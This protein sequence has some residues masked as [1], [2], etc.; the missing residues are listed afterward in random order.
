MDKV[1]E[2]GLELL[3]MSLVVAV[4]ACFLAAWSVRLY[5]R[6]PGWVDTFHDRLFHKIVGLVLA[7]LLA[8]LAVDVVRTYYPPIFDAKERGIYVSRFDLDDKNLVQA[9]VFEAVTFMLNQDPAFS[10][11]VVRR[12]DRKIESASEAASLCESTHAVLCIWG[13]YIPPKPVYVKLSKAGSQGMAE[14]LFADYLDLN[15]LGS[16][17]LKTISTEP[18]PARRAATLEARISGLEIAHR[19]LEAQVAD[20]RVSQAYQGGPSDDVEI[21]RFERARRRIAL[22]VGVSDYQNG[23]PRLA[24]GANDAQAVGATV[25]KLWGESADL[26]VLVDKSATR[27]SIL[28]KLD[29]IVKSAGPNDQ[30]LVYLSGHAVETESEGAVFL[31]Y[32]AEAARIASTGIRLHSLFETLDKSKSGQVILLVDT[33]YSAFFTSYAR[34]IAPQKLSA[35][36]LSNAK[37]RVILAAT[38]ANE[39]AFDSQKAGHGIF[40]NS[41]LDGFS[42]KADQNNDGFITAQELGQYSL[43]KVAEDARALG[44][45]QHPTYYA[46]PMSDNLVVALTR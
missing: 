8:Y 40:T 11:V 30:I 42:G 43:Y 28:E 12:L 29:S 20:L 23:L 44:F 4:T 17:I 24:F 10:D 14:K 34:G 32:D 5:R 16:V 6:Q 36:Q 1:I 35:N 13:A 37:G 38:S 19:R 18:R 2:R 9:H 15:E 46:T 41:I 21:A 3:P 22:M 39:I 27:A 33:C 7:G 26:T 45:E 31:A 25:G